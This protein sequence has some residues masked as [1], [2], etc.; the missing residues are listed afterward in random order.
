MASKTE[1]A[2]MSIGNLGIGKEIANLDTEQSQEASACR[3]YFDTARDAS[4]RDFPWPFAGVNASLN[5]VETSPN[6]EW[7]YSYRYPVDCVMVRRIMTGN[8]N[9]N[10]NERE[11]YSI[12][13]DDAG[14]LIFSDKASAEIEYTQQVIDS[15]F[16]SADFTIAF[17]FRLSAYTA[18]RLTKGD[19][20]KMKTDMLAQYQ[21]EIDT[22]RAN[23]LN[24]GQ[25]TQDA[26]SE[27]IKVRN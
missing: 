6:S 10:P 18:P 27:L 2:N 14:K 20:F 3:R 17:S 13:K 26:D 19:P 21:A 25:P 22:V 5:L 11:P 9:D 4:L 24:E 12:G 15:N 1:I 16:F 8:K 23:A 7:A